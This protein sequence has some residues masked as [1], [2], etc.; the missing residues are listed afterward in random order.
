MNTESKFK[1]L[2]SL[3]KW[4]IQNKYFIK[5]SD[6]KEKNKPNSLFIR[7]RYMEGAT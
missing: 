5:T 7:W 3:K 4:I 1:D 6:P 2:P